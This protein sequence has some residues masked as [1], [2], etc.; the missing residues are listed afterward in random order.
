MTFLRSF[1]YA[2]ASMPEL[3]R[4]AMSTSAD[5]VIFDLEDAVSP[6]QKPAARENVAQLLGEVLVD[7]QAEHSPALHLR[8]NRDGEGYNLD[9]VEVLTAPIQVVRLPKVEEVD[10]VRFVDT[11]VGRQERLAGLTAGGIELCLTVESALGLERLPELV[12]ASP[13]VRQVAWGATDFLADIRADPE[14]EASRAYPRSR[15][16]IASRAGGLRAPIDAVFTA[17]DDLEGLERDTRFGRALGFRG[18]SV[19]HPC[20]LPVVH[21]VYAGTEAEIEQARLIVE[22]HEQASS[23][24]RGAARIDGRFVD[25]AVVRNARRVLEEGN[26]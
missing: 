12:R 10:A 24:G 20:Q 19:I 18:K 3:M 25:T 26:R 22:A 23:S 15:I 11:A 6:D 1:L 13:R 8:I 7:N 5:A 4:K 14:D 17:L 16:V 21:A 2:P 9:D